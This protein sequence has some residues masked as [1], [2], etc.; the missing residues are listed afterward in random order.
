MLGASRSTDARQEE[1][2]RML[3]GSVDEAA[4]DEAGDVEMYLMQ[5]MRMSVTIV[6]IVDSELAVEFQNP[7]VLNSG[8]QFDTT[9]HRRLE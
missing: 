2:K 8:D 4:A 5:M 3:R 9:E 1:H 7:G 6:E